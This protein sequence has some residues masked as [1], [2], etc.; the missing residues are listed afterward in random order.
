MSTA[1]DEIDGAAYSSWGRIQSFLDFIRMSLVSSLQNC[2]F[3]YAASATH[4]LASSGCGS[5]PKRWGMCPWGSVD[6]DGHF[7][8]FCPISPI[9]A[10]QRRALFGIRIKS[11]FAR[12]CCSDTR[13]PKSVP[14]SQWLTTP[15]FC[16]SLK[17]QVGDCR[18]VGSCSY[19]F[20]F[21]DP[22]WRSSPCLQHAILRIERKSKR[23]GRNAQWLFRLLVRRGKASSPLNIGA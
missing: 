15:P 14:K 7:R 6:V 2:C 11:V 9:I 3:I 12:F 19:V 21:W 16:M 22:G 10:Y 5:V 13:F 18:W 1:N 8:F 4:Q 23:P 20:S 17:F